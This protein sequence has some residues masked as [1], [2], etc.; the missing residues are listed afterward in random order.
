[1]ETLYPETKQL[2]NYVLV[3]I[4]S[5][6]AYAQDMKPPLVIPPVSETYHCFI[7][8]LVAMP[9]VQ[10]GRAFAQAPMSQKRVVFLDAFRNAFHDM[11][12]R[13][14]GAQAT[15]W[16]RPRPEEA[17]DEAGAESSRA[18]SRG[19]NKTG[20]L[21]MAM[22]KQKDTGSIKAESKSGD[23]EKALAPSVKSAK[24]TKAVT[25]LDSHFFEEEAKA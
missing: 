16:H 23:A 8:R 4:L 21:E 19:G 15:V 17:E 7:K 22:Q 5:N 1:M 25:L 12:T 13:A 6:A 14:A 3:C 9:D 11:A 18:S 10:Q 20:S 24:E 2:H